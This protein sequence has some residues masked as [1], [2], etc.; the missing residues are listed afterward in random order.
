MIVVPAGLVVGDMN[1]S[2][3]AADMDRRS[4]RWRVMIVRRLGAGETRAGA[5]KRDDR[6]NDGAQERQKDNREIHLSLS[7]N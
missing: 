3:I 6:A 7:S 4:M 2:M 5:G 1:D